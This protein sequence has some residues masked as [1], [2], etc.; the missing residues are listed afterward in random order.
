[1]KKYLTLFLS[2]LL[3]LG[4]VGC[5][6]CI[7][8]LPELQ[9]LSEAY[10]D[11]D[12]AITGLYFSEDGLSDEERAEVESVLK[13]AGALFSWKLAILVAV[14]VEH[15]PNSAECIRCGKRKQNCPT[16]AIQATFSPS[17]TSPS[18]KT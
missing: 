11:K 3:F 17:S 14:D 4:L 18:C 9:K 10:A 6:P 16:V 1:M 15:N 2:A 12:V 5:G 13:N 7:E 8:E